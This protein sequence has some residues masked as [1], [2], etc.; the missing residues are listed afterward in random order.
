VSQAPRSDARQGALVGT[1]LAK[2]PPEADLLA[3]IGLAHELTR[4]EA[5]AELPLVAASQYCGAREVRDANRQQVC[6]GV[7]EVLSRRGSTRAEAALAASIGERTGWSAERVAAA[8]EERDALAQLHLAAQSG[9]AWSCTALAQSLAHFHETARHGELATMR[10]ALRRSPE[11]AA[12]LAQ[13][14]RDAAATRVASAASAAST[15]S[16]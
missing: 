1:V 15:A 8:G 10:N 16:P 6:A 2:L 9:E 14:Y 3:R 5:R 12:V 11:G 7:A 13:R 4:L